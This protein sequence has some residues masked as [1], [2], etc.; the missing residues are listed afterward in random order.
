MHNDLHPS[1]QPWVWLAS[2]LPRQ[3]G[4]GSSEARV[5]AA[6][7]IIPSNCEFAPTRRG[8]VC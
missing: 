1:E 6:A 2:P 4:A 8:Q 7:A 3:E 5:L